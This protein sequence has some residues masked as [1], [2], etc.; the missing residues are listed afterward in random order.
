MPIRNRDTLLN[1]LVFRGLATAAAVIAYTLATR[2]YG[3][4][5]TLISGQ[6]A[7]AQLSNSDQGYLS[8]TYVMS[9]LAGVDGLLTLALALIVLAIWWGPL[10]R[11]IGSKQ[12][13]VLAA[14]IAGQSALLKPVPA[15]AFAETVDKTEAYTILPNESAFWIPDV[16]ANKDN[17]G[18]MD[19]EAYLQERK[20]ALKRFVIP[21]AKLSG[22]GGAAWYST[23][24]DFYVPTG[25]LIIIDRT[26][27]SREWVAQH[28]RGTSARN[29][30]FPCQS[31][32][33]LN[34]SVGVSIGASVSEA[35]AAKYLFRFG[36]LSPGGNRTDPQVIFTSV[37]YG[38][39]LAD[40]M[41][42]VGRKKVQTLVCDQIASRTFDK[43][44]EEAVAIMT[45]VKKDAAEYFVSVGITLDFLGWA[46]TFTF[47]TDVQQAVNRRFIAAKD[48][49]I[50]KLLAPHAE[51]IQALAA[52]QALRHF[53]ERSD[54]KLPTTIVGLPADVGGL[55]NTLLKASAAAPASVP[56]QPK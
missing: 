35:N 44:N 27:Y 8:A 48:E 29:E 50:A 21:H 6:A 1:S 28:D 55:L 4:Q 15:L 31:K 45:S 39:K 46:D 20:I 24:W 7:G 41:D 9:L 30:S 34:I 19:S 25:R 37:Y 17:Q 36:V 26:T 22:S 11:L 33:G 47:D 2:L 10:R 43:V 38:R 13:A 5:A 49:E 53:G 32:E 42:D 3:P 54:G 18:Q 14:L 16:G 40:V 51:T 23:G 12:L 52:A 56:A